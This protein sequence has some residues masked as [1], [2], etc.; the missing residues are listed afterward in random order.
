MR[1]IVRLLL[2]ALI[3]LLLVGAIVGVGARETGAAEK[4]VLVV[5]A[6]ALVWAAAQVRRRLA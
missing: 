1:R 6:F 3:A 4:A 2:L 5:L